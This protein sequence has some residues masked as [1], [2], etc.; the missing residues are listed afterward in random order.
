MPG[1]VCAT[2]PTAHGPTAKLFARSRSGV[3]IAC[4]EARASGGNDPS[5]SV[6][7]NS[8]TA[9]T[10]TCERKSINIRTWR[11]DHKRRLLLRGRHCSVHDLDADCN[12]QPQRSRHACRVIADPDPASRRTRRRGLGGRGQR[13]S[14]RNNV[15]RVRHDRVG[16]GERRARRTSGGIDQ[17]LRSHHSL[18]GRLEASIERGDPD[19][20]GDRAPRS[21]SLI[22]GAHY[23]TQL[24]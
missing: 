21:R 13:R 10:P 9:K 19:G 18:P 11:C 15:H 5:M 16:T 24:S 4:S 8:Q 3:Q 23:Q 17:E 20:C 14:S 7:R 12:W 6:V 2:V 1:L 22:D